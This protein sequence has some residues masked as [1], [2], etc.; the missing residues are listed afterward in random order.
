[1]LSVNKKQ[2]VDTEALID[3]TSHHSNVGRPQECYAGWKK[4]N[5]AQVHLQEIPRL[6]E[7]VTRESRRA[8]LGDWGMGTDWW[9][10]C[11]KTSGDGCT[12]VTI[13]ETIVLDALRTTLKVT[14]WSADS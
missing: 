2:K 3:S 4:L 12:A 8:V 5:S 11:F 10:K 1:M 9:P 7:S 6:G 13:L 14:A